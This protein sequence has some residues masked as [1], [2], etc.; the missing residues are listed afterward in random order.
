MILAFK[1]QMAEQTQ[2]LEQAQISRAESINRL[3]RSLEESQ[4]QCQALLESCTPFCLTDISRY[5]TVALF[6]IPH[7]D[8]VNTCFECSH[9]LFISL[10]LFYPLFFFFCFPSP[11]SH[12]CSFSLSILRMSSYYVIIFL[13][14]FYQAA[15]AI[16]M[17]NLLIC[18]CSFD[19]S[20]PILKKR[21]IYWNFVYSIVLS[22]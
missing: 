5:I 10:L 12:T 4:R 17:S 8:N 18:F 13:C 1:R 21:Y 2:L 20:F 19:L 6:T 15:I 14:H 16:K 22:Y 11:L 7:F 3:T 9:H